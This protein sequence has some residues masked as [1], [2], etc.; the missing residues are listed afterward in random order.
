MANASAEKIRGVAS[1]NVPAMALGE[2]NPPLEE[3]APRVDWI[4]AGQR[5]QDGRA[6]EP[7][8]NREYRRT[9]R[10]QP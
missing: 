3:R 2:P 8:A 5:D 9:R 10:A 1:A 6:Q 4:L 7:K